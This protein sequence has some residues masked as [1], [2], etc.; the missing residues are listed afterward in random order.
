MKRFIAGLLALGLMGISTASWAEK[1]RPMPTERNSINQ[2]FHLIDH[3]NLSKSDI[4]TRES[5]QDMLEMKAQLFQAVRT[6]A[7]TPVSEKNG[8]PP[9]PL[10]RSF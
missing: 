2:I 7:A 10:K 8:P 4:S 1:R 5:V 9:S 6:P 3:V